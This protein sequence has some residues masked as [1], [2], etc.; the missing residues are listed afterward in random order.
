MQIMHYV[1]VVDITLFNDLERLSGTGNFSQ[2]AKLG[3]ISQPAFSRRIKTLEAWVGATLVDRSRQPVKLTAAGTQM[4][5]VGLQSLAYIER[6]RSQILET[7]SLPEK[8][9][10]A[11]GEQHSISWRF[12]T[13]WLRAFEESYGPILSRLR[14]DDLPHCMRDLQNGDVDFV[15]AYTRAGEA[16]ADGESIVIGKDRLVLVCQPDSEGKPIFNFESEDVCIPFLQFGEAAPISEHLVSMF[17]DHKL[18][19]RLQSVY[20]NSMAGALL[21]R[22]RDGTGVAWLPESLI[23]A[24]LVSKTLVRTGREDWTVAL[25]IRLYRNEQYSN[26]LTRS[27]WS[28]LEARQSLSLLSAS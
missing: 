7:Q 11:F 5:E 13:N 26:R 21:I 14:A 19:P 17:Q 24:D 10:V 23:D 22:A 20:E 2:A 27:I 6:E 28:F 25:D 4:L 3:N 18:E 16:P 15:I 12:Y 1:A 9:I 8:Y